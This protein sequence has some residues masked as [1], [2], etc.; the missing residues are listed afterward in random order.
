MNPSKV[1]GKTVSTGIM[2]ANSVIDDLQKLDP[3]K[4]NMSQ[5][6]MDNF[7][8]QNKALRAWFYIRL[9][10]AFRNV[11]LAVSLDQ[12]KTLFGQV[13]LRRVV[14]LYLKRM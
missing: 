7:I 14:Q 12:S 9:L 13:M 11:P 10:D 2:Q 4:F 8:A 6:E 1:N 3:A 5:P